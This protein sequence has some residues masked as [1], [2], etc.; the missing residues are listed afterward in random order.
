MG[1][2]RNIPTSLSVRAKKRFVKVHRRSK[3]NEELLPKD[4]LVSVFARVAS[5]SFEDLYNAKLRLCKERL[6]KVLK[7]EKQLL[8]R[9]Y[10]IGNALPALDKEKLNLAPNAPF[11]LRNPRGG[12]E[13]E[14]WVAL[15]SNLET[16]V[17][18]N[19]CDRWIWTGDGD[20]M[21]NHLML[22][23]DLARDVWALAGRWWTLDFPSVLTIREL[24]SWVDDTRL[25]ILAKKVLHVVV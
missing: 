7:K 14:Q 5:S 23:C 4:V 25:H 17:S 20:E 1:V 13:K 8:K 16:Y 15:F 19:Q 11:L 2:P 18:S 12:A 9:S 21:V 22:H 10:K 24:M 6:L 3:K